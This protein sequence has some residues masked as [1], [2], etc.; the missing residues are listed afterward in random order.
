[1]KTPMLESLFN[2]VYQKE[3]PTQ[4][5]SCEYDKMFKSSYFEKHL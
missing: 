4:A 1:M 2:K 5:F 3:T